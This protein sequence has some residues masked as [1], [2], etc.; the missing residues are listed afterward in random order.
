MDETL[1]RI[2]KQSGGMWAETADRTQTPVLLVPNIVRGEKVFELTLPVGEGHP[3]WRVNERAL[4]EDEYKEL[5][6]AFESQRLMSP[7]TIH[8]V[9]PGPVYRLV[10]YFIRDGR[11]SGWNVATRP[12]RVTIEEEG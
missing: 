11:R 6:A 1:D 3:F 4:T 7:G 5:S 10:T 9:W 12:V 2:I 8:Q